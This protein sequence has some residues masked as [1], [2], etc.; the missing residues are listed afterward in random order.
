MANRISTVLDIDDKGFRG[1]LKSIGSAVGEADGLF[2]KFKAGTSAGLDVLKQNAGA[3]AVAGGAALVAFGIK[4]VGAFTDTA[5]AAIDLGSVTGL[6]VEDASRWIG[7]GDDFKVTAEDLTTSIGKIGKGLD[8]AKW[9]K[10]GIATRDAGGQ[11]RDANDIL[12]DSLTK[13]SSVTNETER[14]RI[15]NDLFGKG[16]AKLAPLVGHTRDEYEK[17]LGSVEKG[18]VITEAEAAKAE[19]FRLAQDQLGD[20]FKEVTIAIGEQVA[21]LAPLLVKAAQLIDILGV[22]GSEAAQAT[23]D[24]FAAVATMREEYDKSGTSITHWLQV[25]DEGNLTLDQLKEKMIDANLTVAEATERHRQQAEQITETD[26]ETRKLVSAQEAAKTAAEN[27]ADATERAKQKSEA[28][29]KAVEDERQALEKLYSAERS[30]VDS[31]YAFIESTRQANEDLTAYNKVLG[32]G[33]AKQED[34]DAALRT[35]SDSILQASAD[36]A[37]LNGATLSSKEGI[38][39]QIASLAGVRDSLAPGSPLRAFIQEYIDDLARIPTS[40]ETELA[41]TKKGGV[42]TGLATK[43]FASGTSSAPSGLALVGE[44]GPELVNF[45]GGESVTPAGQTAALLNGGGNTINL[46]VHAGWGADGGVIGNAIVTELKKF[47]RRNGNGW[48]S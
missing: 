41:V 18:Q 47:E 21:A 32:D 22:G 24:L 26:R 10:Y 6:A 12:L 33:K 43:A 42:K 19:K 1:S 8:N 7:V 14:A 40:I 34:I 28:H 31:K 27:L 5:K 45:N 48:R 9:E 3:F 11:A 17:M 20:A 30:A 15:G 46:I 16:Y 25:M 4:A 23:Q 29:F 39:R 2:G 38:D 37:T 44:Q 36:Y 35:A 13:L